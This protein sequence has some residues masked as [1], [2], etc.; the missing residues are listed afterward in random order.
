MRLL[1]FNTLSMEE[2][3]KDVPNYEGRYEINNFGVLKSILKSKEKFLKGSISKD[4]YRQYTL[5][6]RGKYNVYGGHQLVAM[7]FLDHEPNGTKSLVVDHI[8]NNKLDNRL[9]NLQLL[10]NYRNTVKLYK[11]TTLFGAIKQGNRYKARLHCNGTY[12]Y[13]GCF[14]TEIEA[15][16]KVLQYMKDNNIKRNIY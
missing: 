3:W 14:K 5:N 10:S 7:A 11:H 13:L 15:H 9:E 4:G 1:L 8:N 2:I 6:N 12:L 16:N